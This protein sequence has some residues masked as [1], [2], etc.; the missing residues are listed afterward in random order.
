MKQIA[1]I[2]GGASG[3]IAAY[4]AS[5]K[6]CVALFEKQD[7]IGKKILITGNGR[8]NLSNKFIDVS[9][10]HGKNPKF[11]LNIFSKF[12]LEETTLFFDSIGIPIIELMDGKLYPASLQSSTI[13]KIFNYE[14]SKRG[15]NI[16]LHSRIDKIIPSL[17]GFKIITAGKDEH[18]FDSVILSTGSCAYPQLGGSRIGYEI[19]LSLKHKVYDPFPVILPINIPSKI[20]HRVQ[21]VKRN[22]RVRVELKGKL[23]TESEGEL[24]FTKYGISGPTSLNISRV[25]NENV[26]QGKSPEIIIDLFPHFSNEKLLNHLEK[27]WKNREK[28]ITFSL[29]GILN[30]RI[31]ELIINRAGINPETIVG[32]LTEVEKKTIVSTLKSF[33]LLPGK[34]RSFRDG[35]TAAG[36]VDV[37]EVNPGTMESKIVKNLYITGELLDIDGDSGGYN[38]QFAWS[39]GAIAGMSQ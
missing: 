7:K 6:N 23:L 3:L 5:K 11:V 30:D 24:L 36:G 32:D 10:Y 25:V 13:T 38:L 18:Q 12:G 20:T 39:T 2:G 37:D 26:L 9:H 35:V 33:T 14:L 21:G 34:P 19:A 16:K 4:Y 8:C 17:S 29:I 27:L 28:K 22:C 31:P 15:V 1:I